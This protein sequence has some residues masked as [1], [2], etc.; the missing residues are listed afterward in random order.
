MSADPLSSALAAAIEPIVERA[1]ERALGELVAR[2]AAPAVLDRAGLARGLGCSV[3]SIDRLLRE[4]V[5]HVRLGSDPRFV[6][7][8]VIRWLQSRESRP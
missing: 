1:V 2:Q 4:G 3:A 7:A 6:L 5:P 8:D